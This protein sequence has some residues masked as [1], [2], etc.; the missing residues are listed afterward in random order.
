M[1]LCRRGIKNKSIL[2]TRA[3]VLVAIIITA[4]LAYVGNEVDATFGM[5]AQSTSVF[6]GLCVRIFGKNHLLSGTALEKLSQVDSILIALPISILV[7][8]VV[9][10]ATK[11]R[12]GLDQSHIDKCFNGVK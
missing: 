4:V 6:F 10:L 7:L 2:L 3:G 12:T 9:A 11:Q 8:V 1:D 5:I